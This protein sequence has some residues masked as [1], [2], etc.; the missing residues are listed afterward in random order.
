MTVSSSEP[1][2]LSSDFK[3]TVQLQL[4]WFK[5]NTEDEVCN[6]MVIHPNST[7]RHSASGIRMYDQCNLNSF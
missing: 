2:T 7:G 4:D 1:E 5:E 6:V 3:E